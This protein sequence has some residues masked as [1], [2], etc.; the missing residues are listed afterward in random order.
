MSKAQSDDGRILMTADAGE[1]VTESNAAN[2]AGRSTQ[3]G[4]RRRGS[5]AP[6]SSGPPTADDPEATIPDRLSVPH[7]RLVELVAF[8]LPTFAKPAAP[9][10]SQPPCFS[11]LSIFSRF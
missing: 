10:T 1:M 3:W 2:A 11:Y 8:G 9:I 4:R 7:T 6:P 5:K